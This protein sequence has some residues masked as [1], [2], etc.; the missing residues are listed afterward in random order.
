MTTPIETIAF[1]LADEYAISCIEGMTHPVDAD[2]ESWQSLDGD[3]FA[4]TILEALDR[5]IRYAEARGL[6]RRH[7]T[8]PELVQFVEV[9][10]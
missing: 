6:I 2:G 5:E 1:E 8:R 4:G 3:L 9:P 7:A 10:E